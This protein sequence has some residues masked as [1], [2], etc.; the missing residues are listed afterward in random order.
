MPGGQVTTGAGRLKF[1][2]GSLLEPASA[3][4]KRAIFPSGGCGYRQWV[5]GQE[6]LPR[7]PG[8]PERANSAGIGTGVGEGQIVLPIT[9]IRDRRDRRAGRFAGP[10]HG[11]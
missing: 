8:E 10:G 11:R 1:N 9:P 5:A 7:N 6:A 2:G 4:R 3:L